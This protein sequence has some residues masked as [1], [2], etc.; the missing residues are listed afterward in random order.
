MATDIQMCR[1]AGNLGWGGRERD[2]GWVAGGA[3]E[4]VEGEVW[5]SRARASVEMCRREC[6]DR[7]GRGKGVEMR[8]IWLA[9]GGGRRSRVSV[10]AWLVGS[11][12]GS[13]HGGVV[14]G[15][16]ERRPSGRPSG[17]KPAGPPRSSA[18]RPASC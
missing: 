10:L 1:R 14:A 2:I 15:A 11:R 12:R 4:I 13:G 17:A 7:S 8:K 5:C 9:L 16:R 3:A 6:A 18:T